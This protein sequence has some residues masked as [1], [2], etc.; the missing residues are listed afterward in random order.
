MKLYRKNEI[1]LAADHVLS[2]G[3]KSDFKVIKVRPIVLS[4]VYPEGKELVWVGGTIK[5]WDAGLVEVTLEDGTTGIGEA[6]AAIMAAPA[7][8]GLVDSYAPYLIG[9]SFNHPLS[10]GD[11]LRAY[12]AF[13]SRGGIANGVAGAI[14]I[15][16]I[17]EVGKRE[18]LPAF[19]IM[20]GSSKSSIEVYASGGLGTSFDE[21]LQWAMIQYQNGFDTVKFRAMRDPKT[22]LE[23]LDYVIPKL[24][25]NKKF[26]LD[27]VQGCAANPWELEESINVGRLASKYGA[28]WYEEPCFADDVVGYAAVEKAVDAPISGVESHGTYQE[29]QSLIDAHGV[30]IAQPDSTFVGGANTF[31]RVADYAKSHGVACVPHVWGSAV[32]YMA[33][34]HASF[35]HDHIQ[36]F[37]FC[38]LPNELRDALFAEKISF[39][40][41]RVDRPVL[42]GIGVSVDAEMETRFPYRNV[43]GHVIK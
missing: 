3:G 25:T 38:T 22:T 28:R 31:F 23:L 12:T 20:G 5:S 39:H 43:G 19:E 4:Y 10:V 1:Q 13:W 18:G 24:P 14:E 9:Q 34:L 35:A 30:N 6:G 32:T 8:P 16:C 26:I 41:S 15:A 7:V 17:D 36:L 27:A 29:F 42:P 2:M 37:E 11:H 21:V 33:N 40:D